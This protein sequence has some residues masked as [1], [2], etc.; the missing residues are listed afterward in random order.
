MSYFV[1]QQIISYKHFFVGKL[2]LKK[3][4]EGIIKRKL[5]W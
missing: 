4:G 2:N 1:N 3:L 5:Y